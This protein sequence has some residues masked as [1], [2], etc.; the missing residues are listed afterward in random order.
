[1]GAPCASCA[2]A[3][4]WACALIALTKVKNDAELK[5]VVSLDVLE[6]IFPP[7]IRRRAEALCANLKTNSPYSSGTRCCRTMA[8][9][10]T[11][12]EGK[13]HSSRGETQRCLS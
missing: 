3:T 6:F 9:R 7:G 8:H 10:A 13:K 4:C 5:S 11:T 12:P 2:C 1:M